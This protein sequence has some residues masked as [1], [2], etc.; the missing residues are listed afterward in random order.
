VVVLSR[1]YVVH[2]GEN[3]E[4]APLQRRIHGECVCSDWQIADAELLPVDQVAVHMTR[5]PV[6]VSPTTDIADLARRMLDAHIHRVI[7]VD[8]ENRPVGIISSTDILAAVAYAD[9]VRAT[10][11]TTADTIQNREPVLVAG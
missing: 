8:A 3:E 9:K 7:V 11:G 4:S 2:W 1:T 5:D 10:A 6:T